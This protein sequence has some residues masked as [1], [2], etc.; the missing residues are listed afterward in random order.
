MPT[1]PER[2]ALLVRQ[3]GAGERTPVGEVVEHL[4]EL[5]GIVG[6]YVEQHQEELR[7]GVILVHLTKP[8]VPGRASPAR[9]P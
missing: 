9:L 8:L 1:L 4:D 6:G 2:V 5:A 7:A 3:V